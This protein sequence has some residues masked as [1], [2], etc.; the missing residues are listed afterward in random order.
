MVG[1]PEADGNGNGGGNGRV[2]DGGGGDDVQRAG[3]VKNANVCEKDD[4]GARTL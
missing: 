4:C 1:G 3:N 2:V